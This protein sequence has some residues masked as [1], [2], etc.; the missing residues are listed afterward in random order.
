[1]I[2]TDPT[3]E[4]LASIEITFTPEVTGIPQPITAYKGDGTKAITGLDNGTLYTFTVIAVDIN[5]NKNT[6]VTT[7]VTPAASGPSDTTPPADVT[8]LGGIP[9]DTQ[10]T[11]NWTDPAD[12]DLAFIEVTFTPAATGVTQPIVVAKGV[13]TKIITGLAN[14]TPYTFT[15]KAEDTSNNKT[16][17]ATTEA[18][19][20]AAPGSSDTTPPANVTGL[21]GIPGDA[22]VSLNWTNPTDT[23]LASIQITFTPTADGVAQPIAVDKGAGTKII[24]GLANGTSY[25]FTVKA[26][27]TSGNLNTGITVPLTPRAPDPTD[28]TAPAKVTGLSGT[29]GNARVTLIWTDPADEDLASIEIT[30]IPAV[31]SIEQPIVVA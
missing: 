20:P 23:D 7:A 13:E 2:W 17:G 12:D 8:G 11:L 31:T 14:G 16:T 1:L 27:D 10:V 9:G 29:P 5:N 22:Q 21:G 26:A 3:D 24:S 19:T 4:D 6:G 18:I 15:V 30:F 28:K 25:M